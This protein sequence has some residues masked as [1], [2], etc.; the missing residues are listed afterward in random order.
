MRNFPLKI[1]LLILVLPVF[2][3]AQNP[4]K[5]SLESDAKGKSL[6]AG[7]KFKAALRAEIEDGWHLYALE[8]PEGGPIATTVKVAENVPFII[9][10]KIATTPE[11]V[12]EFDP[13]FNIDT[14]FFAKQAQFNLSLQATAD[15]ARAD[16]L[17]INVRFQLCNDTICLPPKT[18]KVTFTGA[19]DV[20][21]S[22]AVSV[23]PSAGSESSVN[24][25]STTNNGQ[26]TTKNVQPTAANNGLNTDFWSF[27]WLAVTVGALS[28]L[29]PCVFPMIPIT[30]SYFTN[31][32]AGSRAK[33]VRLALVYSIGII[34]T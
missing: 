7:E 17:A 13:N 10:G 28:L 20:R 15:A 29:T 2:V 18:V 19:E 33:S 5:W 30:V 9:E 25:N 26:G 24:L 32:S 12:T 11:P 16:D 23:Q 27:I 3:L 4:A 34:L 8:Q 22:S 6:K 21:K 1:F 31:H 14:K